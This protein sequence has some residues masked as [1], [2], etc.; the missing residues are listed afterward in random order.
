MH[1]PQIGFLNKRHAINKG[2]KNN[3]IIVV[4]KQRDPYFPLQSQLSDARDAVTMATSSRVTAAKALGRSR[5]IAALVIGSSM[6]RPRF[7]TG[8][9]TATQNF[10]RTDRRRTH[11]VFIFFYFSQKYGINIKNENR[12]DYSLLSKFRPSAGEKFD[13]E[14]KYTHTHTHVFYARKIEC[15]LTTNRAVVRA[16]TVSRGYR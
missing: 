13:F 12:F 11:T 2:K 5:E 4:R 16:R 3:N 9:C 15:S 1:Q 7:C 14:N 8:I 10:V 6:V